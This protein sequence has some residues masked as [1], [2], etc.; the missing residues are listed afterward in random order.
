M[1]GGR[2]ATA[3][4]SLA[5]RKAAAREA[6]QGELRRMAAQICFSLIGFWF[7]K[8]KNADGRATLAF[9]EAM[10]ELV[11]KLRAGNEEA[12]RKK[13]SSSSPL[14][15]SLAHSVTL[16]GVVPRSTPSFPLVATLVLLMALFLFPFSFPYTLRRAVAGC[17]IECHGLKTALENV[18]IVNCSRRSYKKS[19]LRLR[20]PAVADDASYLARSLPRVLLPWSVVSSARRPSSA[21]PLAKREGGKRFFTLPT[22]EKYGR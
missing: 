2:E 17:E 11:K 14:A 19:R 18:S 7:C 10:S 4:S 21:C 5:D 22:L 1:E 9:S 16:G 6:R 3:A 12:G 13:A 20:H 8:L 15:H